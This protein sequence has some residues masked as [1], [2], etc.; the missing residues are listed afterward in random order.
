MAISRRTN[1]SMVRSMC[2]VKLVDRKNMEDLMEMLGLKET[3]D[4]MAQVNGVK[5]YGQVIRRY[6]DNILIK[7]MMLEVNGQRKRRRPKMIWR[8]QVVGREC[9]KSGIKIEESVGRTRWREGKRAIA[10]EM[11]CIRLLL[12]TRKKMIETG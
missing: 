4:R 9:E 3:L 8:R 7:A 11:R 12:A 10:E 6:D 5:W 1:R 2:G